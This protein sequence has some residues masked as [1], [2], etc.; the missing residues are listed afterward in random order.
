MFSV[1]SLLL[2][3]A[4]TSQVFCTELD[5]FETSSLHKNTSSNRGQTSDERIKDSSCGNS[6]RVK[7]VLD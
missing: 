5:K 6:N 2:F 4:L 3:L 1:A 7:P